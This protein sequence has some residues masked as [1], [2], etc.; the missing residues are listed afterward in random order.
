MSEKYHPEYSQFFEG[1]NKQTI[2]VSKVFPGARQHYGYGKRMNGIPN[3]STPIYPTKAELQIVHGSTPPN[4][5]LSLFIGESYL[6]VSNTGKREN[7]YDTGNKP[8]PVDRMIK[9]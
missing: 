2:P 4:G 9:E 3:F 5:E 1:A 6:M 7:H 8:E